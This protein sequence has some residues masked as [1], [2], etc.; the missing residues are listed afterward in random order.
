MSPHRKISAEGS[1]RIAFDFRPRVST[2]DPLRVLIGFRYQAL[3]NPRLRRYLKARVFEMEA[4]LIATACHEI[5]F[6]CGSEPIIECRRLNTQFFHERVS[7]EGTAA[8]GEHIHDFE[9][10][11]R[12]TRI[13]AVLKAVGSVPGARVEDHLAVIKSPEDK[14]LFG[15]AAALTVFN[16]EQEVRVELKR[17][18]QEDPAFIIPEQFRLVSLHNILWRVARLQSEKLTRLKVTL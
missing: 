10:V 17:R 7:I 2:N 18:L 4:K 13:D 11:A 3:G 14:T 9:I 5:F 15:L 8:F 1:L 16:V 6:Q 12:R